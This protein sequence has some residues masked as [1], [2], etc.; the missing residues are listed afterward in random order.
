MQDGSCQLRG[1]SAPEY[2]APGR[3][4]RSLALMPRGPS[5]WF[6]VRLLETEGGAEVSH[7][8]AV[9][10]GWSQGWLK[11]GWPRCPHAVTAPGKGP[12]W[13][14]GRWVPTPML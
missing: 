14:W 4:L 13:L 9:L 10:R 11:A 12:L 1:L 7:P 2:Q 3:Q 5:A 6:V 8:S